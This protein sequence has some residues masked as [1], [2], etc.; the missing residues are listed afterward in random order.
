MDRRLKVLAAGSLAAVLIRHEYKQRRIINALASHMD[1]L[2]KHLD[3]EFQAR[4]D[5][6]F[7]EMIQDYDN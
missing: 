6:E 1:L 4:V 5:Y 2:K 3:E 7:D